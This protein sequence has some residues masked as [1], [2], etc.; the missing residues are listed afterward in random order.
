MSNIAI[1]KLA[2]SIKCS[3]FENDFKIFHRRCKKVAKT[4]KEQVN[5]QLQISQNKNV[6]YFCILFSKDH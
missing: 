1:L 2:V 3:L 4:V 5:E 6:Y